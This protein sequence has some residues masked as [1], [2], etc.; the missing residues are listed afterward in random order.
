MNQPATLIAAV[1]AALGPALIVACIIGTRDALRTIRQNTYVHLSRYFWLY[2]A[3]PVVMLSAL[4]AGGSVLVALTGFVL[5]GFRC[6]GSR[7]APR[8]WQWFWP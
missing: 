2:V 7:A 6:N 3:A 4:A 8:V 5:G 1:G